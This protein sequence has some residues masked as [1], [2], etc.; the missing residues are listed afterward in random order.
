MRTTLDGALLA[1]LAA[2]LA[3]FDAERARRLPGPSGGRLPVHTC[4]VPADQATEDLPAWWG[5][6][7]LAALDRH[8][9]DAAALAG[10]IGLPPDLASAVY[11]E[12]RAKLADEPVE[13]LRLDFAVGY[14]AHDTEDAEALRA[15]A[16]LEVWSL[17]SAGIR[18]GPF[19]TPERYRRSVR[20]LDLVV[21][22]LGRAPALTFPGV[23]GR[24]QVRVLVQVLE[25]LE[26]RLGL[27]DGELRFEIQ[28]ESPDAVIDHE[29]RVAV[30]GLVAAG[31]GRVVGLHFAA[32]DYAVACG[33]TPAPDHPACDYAR[34]TLQ[35][36][37]AGTGVWLSDGSADLLP[38]GDAV[39]SGWRAHYAQVRRA[40][41]H[42]FPR[43]WDVHPAQ[44]VTRYA[45]VQTQCGLETTALR[46]PAA[47]YGLVE[48]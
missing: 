21:T 2:E 22:A 41:A 32:H 31:E 29:G 48:Q 17:P 4:L 3:Q 35:V 11:A 38:F 27:P 42:G 37:A 33:L 40:Q 26:R 34:H 6:L 15:A 24:T 47:R 28:V 45:A 14:R 5:A 19:D 12:V 43:G 20:T 8:A 25:V 44:L 13:D 10:I 39:E 18:I 30:P 23:T 16:L 9:P 1:G 46:L 7:A 36:G